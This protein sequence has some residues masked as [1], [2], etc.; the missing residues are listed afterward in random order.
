MLVPFCRN[1]I[2][3][4][5]PAV[6]AFDIAALTLKLA[7]DDRTALVPVCCALHLTGRGHRFHLRAAHTRLKRDTIFDSLFDQLMSAA[8]LNR[9]CFGLLKTAE[10]MSQH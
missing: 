2:W 7:I 4:Q 3:G 8:E 10:L 1:M 6:V 5:I 9:L